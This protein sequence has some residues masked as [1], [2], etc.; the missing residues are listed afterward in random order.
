M[1]TFA[2]S[3]TNNRQYIATDR[4]STFYV[5]SEQSRVDR[6]LLYVDLGTVSAARW[7]I[8]N[9]GN[10]LQLLVEHGA[11]YAAR[12]LR[13]MFKQVWWVAQLIWDLLLLPALKRIKAVVLMIWESPLL[14]SAAALGT[15]LEFDFLSSIFRLSKLHYALL[16]A[17]SHCG[18]G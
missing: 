4:T 10:V 5:H 14:S 1:R 16:F 3:A 8:T 7:A 12:A 17:I 11:A 15:S 9:A 6:M 13:W 2:W 18:L